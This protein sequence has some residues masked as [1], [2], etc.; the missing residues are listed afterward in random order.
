VGVYRAV[1]IALEGFS[2]PKDHRRRKNNGKGLCSRGLGERRPLFRTA[3]I[4]INAVQNP[5]EL[6]GERR[7]FWGVPRTLT[8]HIIGFARERQGAREACA[9]CVLQVHHIVPLFTPPI[10]PEKEVC[11]PLT[12]CVDV[13]LVLFH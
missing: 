9:H 5:L 1:A 7:L 10:R 4:F 3:V 6:T 12:A 13:D 2:V 8:L 11:G